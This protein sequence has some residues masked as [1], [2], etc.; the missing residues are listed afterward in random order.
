MIAIDT[1]VLL[2]A[3]LHDSDPAQSARAQRAIRAHAPVFLND[4]VLVEF[5]WTCKSVFKLDR[6][7]IHQRL[8]A[9]VEAPEFAFAR[10]EAVDRAVRAYGSRKSDF[11]D[12]LIGESNFDQGCSTTITFDEGAVKGGGFK[13]VDV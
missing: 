13:L 3:F 2:R 9:I 5:A 10:P 8:E 6:A 1:N 7:A 12:R 11:A 4:I